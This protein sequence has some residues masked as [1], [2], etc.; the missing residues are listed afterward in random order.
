M[1]YS[2]IRSK[3]FNS[4]AYWEPTTYFPSQS[5][6][7]TRISGFMDFVKLSKSLFDE[8]EIIILVKSCNIQYKKPVKFE[9]ELEIVSKVIS[10]SRTSFIM[11]QKIFINDLEV[12]EAEV[13]LVVVNKQGKPTEIPEVLNQLF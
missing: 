13:H 5:D 8:N 6:P 10:K 9:D 1:E 7:T 4:F 12:T 3:N 2:P 11:L